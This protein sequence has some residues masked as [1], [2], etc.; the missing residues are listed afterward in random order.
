MTI[1]SKIFAVFIIGAF[2]H[3]P[4]TE[5]I[6]ATDIACVAILCLSGDGG[7]SCAPSLSKFFSIEK[8]T[9]GITGGFSKKLTKIARKKFLQ[10]CDASD[11]ETI[12]SIIE[13]HGETKIVPPTPAP[14]PPPSE[15]CHEGMGVRCK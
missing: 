4:I 12:R 2:S 7:Q 10:K 1:K 6:G 3:A 11:N 13:K 15:I 8:F 5:A 9:A 14:N